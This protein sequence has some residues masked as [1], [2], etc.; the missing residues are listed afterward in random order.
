MGFYLAQNNEKFSK[1]V[2]FDADSFLQ[3]AF[4]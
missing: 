1:D 2:L 3:K 4:I